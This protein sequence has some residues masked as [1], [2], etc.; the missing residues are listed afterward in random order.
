MNKEIIIEILKKLDDILP[1][2]Q[3]AGCSMAD[4]TTIGQLKEYLLKRLGESIYKE[5]KK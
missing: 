1:I 4:D 5:N 2:L 3:K